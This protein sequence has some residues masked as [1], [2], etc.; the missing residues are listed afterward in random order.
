MLTQMK[1][2]DIPTIKSQCIQWRTPNLGHPYMQEQLTE[3]TK[4]TFHSPSRKYHE[5]KKQKKEKSKKLVT[6]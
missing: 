3:I 1:F 6:P 4:K 5:K 2:Q